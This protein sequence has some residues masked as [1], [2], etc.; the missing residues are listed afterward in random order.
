MK[1]TIHKALI[2]LFAVGFLSAQTLP[3]TVNNRAKL[4][5]WV[6]TGT[7]TF[8]NKTLTSPTITGPTFSGTTT[9]GGPV[10]VGEDGTGYD[11]TFYGET[12]SCLTKLDASEDL[13]SVDQTNASTSGT[14]RAMTVTLTQTGA[15]AISEA[16][17][18]KVIADVKTGSW[19]N[20]LAGRIDYTTGTSGDASGGMAA[21][22]CGEINLPPKTGS[23]GAYY[24]IDLE[25]EAP[26]NFESNTTPTSFP[27]AYL[28]TGL[29]GNSTAKGDWQDYGYI[30]HFDDLTDAS[31]NVWY[32]NT[33]RVLV[34][35]SAFYIPLSDAEGEY[36]SAYQIDISNATDASSTTTGSIQTDGGVGI[37]KKL[38][39]GTDL[40]VDG[41]SNLDAVDIDGDADLAGKLWVSAD[42]DTVKI[43]A[44]QEL[45]LID[46]EVGDATKFAVDTT[47][48]IVG[49][50]AG[51]FD[52][53]TN[54]AFEWNE[55]SD[56]LIW[57]F[58]SNTVTASSGDVTTFDYGSLALGAASLDLSEGN[59][60]NAGVVN[61]DALTAD[62]TNIVVN[63]PVQHVADGDT[64]KI[65]PYQAGN[66]IDVE[67]GNARIA[68]VDTTGLCMFPAIN[69]LDDTST[70]G[71]TY[72]GTITPAPAALKK[73]MFIVMEPG[74][75][76][77]GASTLAFNGLTSKDIK[78]VAGNDPASADIDASGI[79]FL[80]YN[81]TQWVLLNPATT[82]D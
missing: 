35:G 47:G 72:G 18:A 48:V 61:L 40:A 21:A 58:G 20:A 71:D 80:V 9:F 79:S 1:Q 64:V 75:D 59:L 11:V 34:E 55:N 3:E 66:I 6:R 41:T 4:A 38:Y 51:T 50:N 25:V 45:Y 23:G 49:A 73:G 32:D 31:G 12:A 5:R 8:T 19:V 14:E 46:A 37:A 27:M 76:N 30:F 60:T 42:D 24:A 54:N 77:S 16:L 7:F 68:A 78:T 62:G 70:V 2:L 26:E 13:F 63:S 43:N 22:I 10:N 36:S 65:D 15:G 57:T 82:C 74:A 28:R 33:L 29:F 39:V 81:G 67:V 44:Y 53:S 52:N 56:E 17:Y 69:F